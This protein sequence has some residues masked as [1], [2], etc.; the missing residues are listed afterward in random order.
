MGPAW[1]GQWF[2]RAF[3]D[4]GQPLGSHVNAEARI[5]LIAQAWAVLSGAAPPA[6][7]RMALAAVDTHLVDRG[8]PGPAADPPLA[9]AVPSAGYIQA[10][11]PGVR[12]NGG[13]YSHA[14]SGR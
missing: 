10:Y 5:D 8:R 7:Q 14:G 13:Q 12:E 6:L 9:H 4:D 11:P 3:F 2:K 1:D